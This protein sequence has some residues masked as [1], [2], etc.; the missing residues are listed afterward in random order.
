MIPGGCAVHLQ[1]SHL[2][3]WRS[4]EEAGNRGCRVADLHSMMIISD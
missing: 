1:F 4:L 3:D 2:A